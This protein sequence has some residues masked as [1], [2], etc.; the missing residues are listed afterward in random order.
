MSAR[1]MAVAVAAAV[2]AS[3]RIAAERGLT[4]EQA[5]EGLVDQAIGNNA[6]QVIALAAEVES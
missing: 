6:A 3:L 5:L 2:R 4:I 1:E